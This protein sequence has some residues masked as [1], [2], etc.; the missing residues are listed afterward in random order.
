MSSTRIKNR[1]KEYFNKPHFPR[2]AFYLSSRYLSGIHVP[3]KER[4]IKSHFITPLE[5]GVI[6]PSFNKKNI[7]NGPLLKKRLKEGLEKLHLTDQKIACLVPELSLIAFVLSFDSLPPSFQEREQ[8]IRFRVKKQMA[9]LPEDARLSFDVI[10]SDH[11]E[12]VLVSV[13]R[14]SIIQDYEDFLRQVG[15]K[16]RGVGS[17]V[18]SL[19]N[20]VSKEEDGEFLLINI[21]EE[22]LSLVAIINSEIV[23]YRQ[24]PFGL[25]S[26][27]TAPSSQI[28]EN[29]IREVENTANFVEDREKK[30][31]TSLWIRLG[32]LGS[33]EEI[34]SRLNKKLSLHLK[35]IDVPLVSDLALNKRQFLS[36][37]IGQIL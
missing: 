30:K 9:F 18:L 36:P 8:I 29:I 11:S 33:E 16:V 17:P 4:K 37:L 14:A 25:E 7:Q 15:L 1:I 26:Q 35:R 13:A 20:V 3:P 24:K 21:E 27:A 6:E 23:L 22:S 28:I 2:S 5:S 10:K 31:V 19:Y 12:K 34:F 32:L